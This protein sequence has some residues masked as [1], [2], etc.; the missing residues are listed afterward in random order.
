M[1]GAGGAA[2]G[3]IQP[4]LEQQP[5]SLTITN[6]TFNKAQRLAEL[7]VSHGSVVAKEMELIEEQ[8][9]VIINS[10]SASLNGELPAISAAIFSPDSVS[11]DMMYGKNLTSFNQWAKEQ[12]VDNTYDGLGMLVGQAAES[13]ML[14][15]GLRPET[16]RVLGELRKSLDEDKQ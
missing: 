2:R 14:W 16:K 15:R 4:L 1:I 3:V 8:F 10:T 7:F 9:D 13:F 12:G 11:Y 5:H 6:R